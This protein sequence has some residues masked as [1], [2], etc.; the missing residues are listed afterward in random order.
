MLTFI[1]AAVL[2]P[3]QVCPKYKANYTLPPAAVAAAKECEGCNRDLAEQ[4][5]NGEDGLTRDFDVAEYFLCHA[6]EEMAPAEFTG[7][8]EHLQKMRSG[9]EQ[10]P[11]RFC[12]HVT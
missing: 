2:T 11:L 3:E 8:F 12:D 10:A 5:A 6:E 7:M 4:F 9:E 1:L